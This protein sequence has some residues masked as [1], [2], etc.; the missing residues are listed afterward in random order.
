MNQLLSL[1]EIVYFSKDIHEFNTRN[2]L[3]TKVIVIYNCLNGECI[4]PEFYFD[5]RFNIFEIFDKIPKA[6]NRSRIIDLS[7]KSREE[8]FYD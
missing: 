8:I 5:S 1:A 6:G 4:K 2:R 7:D 3:C